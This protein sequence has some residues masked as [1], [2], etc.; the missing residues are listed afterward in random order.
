M[1]NLTYISPSFIVA[2]LK[3]SVSF[4]TDLLGFDVRYMAPDDDPFFAI[5]GRE[6]ISIMLKAITNDILPIPNHTRRRMGTPG[7]IYLCIRSGQL[8]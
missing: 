8:V 2:D 1:V 4:Y 6:T 7:C 5:V 3:D